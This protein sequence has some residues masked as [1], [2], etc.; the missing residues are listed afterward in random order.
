MH[1]DC[2]N[3]YLI[4]MWFCVVHIEAHGIVS[5]NFRFENRIHLYILL[6]ILFIYFF[7][8]YFMNLMDK[9]D[10]FYHWK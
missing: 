6:Y 2:L 9:R 8:S 7:R 1:A 3:A 10:N 4:P 5:D